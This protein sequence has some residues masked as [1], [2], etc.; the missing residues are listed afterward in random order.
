MTTSY[1]NPF[2]DKPSPQPKKE[3]WWESPKFYC[4]TTAG[5]FLAMFTAAAGVFL[6]T[7][8]LIVCLAIASGKYT[9]TELYV[10]EDV[11]DP[12]TH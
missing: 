12:F 8:L 1:G 3:P 10:M 6:Q 11:D 7:V 9:I 5:I 4:Y 2:R